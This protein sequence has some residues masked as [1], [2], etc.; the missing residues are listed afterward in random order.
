MKAVKTSH[1]EDISDMKLDV[2]SKII[3]QVSEDDVR[4]VKKDVIS[5]LK[6]MIR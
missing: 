4:D 1:L 6:G 3:D 5:I 2:L